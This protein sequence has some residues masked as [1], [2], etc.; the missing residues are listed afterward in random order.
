MEWAGRAEEKKRH[1]EELLA[2]QRFVASVSA[3]EPWPFFKTGDIVL[4]E[5]GPLAGLEGVLIQFKNTCRLV[6]VR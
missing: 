5:Q 6:V 1:R 4:V 2:I 3:V